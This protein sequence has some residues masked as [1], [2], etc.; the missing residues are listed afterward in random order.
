MLVRGEESCAVMT[1]LTAFVLTLQV[2]LG[3]GAAIAIGSEAEGWKQESAQS[4]ITGR[5]TL[6]TIFFR[7]FINILITII[8]IFYQCMLF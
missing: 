5:S 4:V 8:V 6:F 3:G 2:T 7:V 1:T